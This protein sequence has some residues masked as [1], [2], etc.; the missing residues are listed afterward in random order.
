MT[1]VR[2]DVVRADGVWYDRI[3]GVLIMVRTDGVEGGV[4]VMAQSRLVTV[5]LQEGHVAE[6]SH[7]RLQPRWLPEGNSPLSRLVW[8]GMVLA[9][10]AVGMLLASCG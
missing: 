10:L 3:D 7:G 9:C 6:M 8:S 2:I 4:A 5:V 1:M